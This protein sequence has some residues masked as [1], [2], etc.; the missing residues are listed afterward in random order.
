MDTRVKKTTQGQN[1]PGL[2]NPPLEKPQQ[3]PDAPIAGGATAPVSESTSRDVEAILQSDVE[4]LKGLLTGIS[5]A[6]TEAGD[7]PFRTLSSPAGTITD[8][9]GNS[10]GYVSGNAVAV[11]VRLQVREAEQVESVSSMTLNLQGLTVVTQKNGEPVPGSQKL[12]AVKFEGGESLDCVDLETADF[13]SVAAPGAPVG[14]AKK[15]T[16]AVDLMKAFQIESTPGSVVAWL[17]SH[18]LQYD[19]NGSR[20]LIF[21]LNDHSYLEGGEF[22]FGYQVKAAAPALEQIADPAD[23]TIYQPGPANQQTSGTEKP[24]VVTPAVE[25]L[26]VI[27]K[28]GQKNQKLMSK[29]S[30][31]V[32]SAARV[33]MGHI[34]EISAINVDCACAD[35]TTG[36][37]DEVIQI[38]QTAGVPNEKITRGTETLSCGR[39]N[40]KLTLTIGFKEGVSSEQRNALEDELKKALSAN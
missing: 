10:L 39:G 18:S 21:V 13:Q 36:F 22:Q 30:Q 37:A 35:Q 34:N 17:K 3:K 1:A 9:D 8:S 14:I 31:K 4:S 20:K 15:D 40:S 26:V 38:L 29:Y 16:L 32:E 7:V 5:P 23:P 6:R 24:G 19:Q 28:M 2:N 25:P 33:I 27:G 11:S 12:C